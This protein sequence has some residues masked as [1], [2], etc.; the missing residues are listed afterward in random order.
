MDA[1]TVQQMINTQ[2]NERLEEIGDLLLPA[3]PKVTVPA[4]PCGK[5]FVTDGQGQPNNKL[6]DATPHN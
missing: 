5:A 1:I 4:Q 3:V 6:D 2:L